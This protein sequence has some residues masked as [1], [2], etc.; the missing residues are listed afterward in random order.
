VTDA[1]VSLPGYILTTVDGG[2]TSTSPRPTTT[3]EPHKRLLAKLEDLLGPMGCHETT[4][5]RWSVLSQQIPIA[6]IAHNFGTVRFGT[7]RRR[8]A[9]DVNCKAHELDNLYVVDT[10]FFPSSGAVNPALTAMADALRV[11]DHILEQLGAPS[12]ARSETDAQSE[13]S[14]M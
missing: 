6:G 13:P 1:G 3:T 12:A 4:L 7:A 5:P 10:S 8:S 2:G 14:D 11:G 9:L